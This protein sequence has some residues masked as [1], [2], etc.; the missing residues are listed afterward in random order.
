MLGHITPLLQYSTTPPKLF[1]DEYFM[2]QALKMAQIAYNQDEI[3]VGAII[4]SQNQIIAKTHNETERL[5]DVTAH[6]EILAI[7]AAAEYLGSKYLQDCTLYVT[8]EPCPMCAGA[9]A[10]AQLGRLVY[11]AR[12]EKRGLHR[13]EPR[14]LHRKTVVKSGI[15]ETDCQELIQI[16]F[17][18]KR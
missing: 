10:W 2:R 5:Q 18:N 12:D 8:L 13:F 1:S 6:A 14:L 3:P 11:G 15:L 4:V 7:T 17:R 16:F 9:L